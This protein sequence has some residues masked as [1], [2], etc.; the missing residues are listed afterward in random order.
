MTIIRDYPCLLH[1]GDYN[2][3]QW[4]DRPDIID[5]DF[6]L[7]DEAGCNTFS[8]AIFS[9]GQLEIGENVFD[10]G[11]LDDIFERAERGGKKLFLATPSGARPGWMGEHYPETN[12]VEANDPSQSRRPW[13]GRQTHCLSSEYFRGKVCNINRK[14]AER[15]GKHPAL[16]GWHVSNE[17]ST[18]CYCPRCLGRY[19]QFLKDR[20]HTL[21]NLNH[22]YWSSFWGHRLTSWSQ[23]DPRDNAVNIAVLD[24]RR[25]V[26]AQIVEFFEMEIAA[27]REYSDLPVTT[28]MMGLYG[29]VDYWKLAKP[30]DFI[31]DDCYPTWYPGITEEV[32]ANFAA[33]HDMHY[34]M[35]KKPFL[36]MESC[37]GIPQYKPYVRLRRPHEFQ[38]EMLLALGHGADGTMYFQWRK[39]RGNLEQHHGAVVGH[40][41]TNQ[42][43]MFK[44]VADYGAHLGRIDEIVDARRTPQ[45][46]VILD[47]ENRWALDLVSGFGGAKVLNYDNTVFQNYQALWSKNYQL[48]VLDGDQD[49]ADCNMA[50]APMLYLLK[51]G[52]AER[53]EAF[54][55]AGGTFVMTYL[56]GCVDQSNRCFLGGNPGGPLLRKVFGIWSEDIDGLTPQTHQQIRWQHTCYDVADYAEV[57]H[58]GE[59]EVLATYV[60]EFYAGTPAV[61]VNR[62]GK[63]RAIYIGARPGLDFLTAFYDSLA[64]AAGCQRL[65]PLLPEPLRVSR[66]VAGDG[67]E[68]YFILNM[69]ETEVTFSLPGPMTDLWSGAGQCRQITLPAAGS[70]VLKA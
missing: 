62:Y 46:A 13:S 6:V 54:V 58:A 8:V 1:G 37:P 36:V 5:Q 65:L 57:I 28:N 70:V 41:G 51:D 22:H 2:P 44:A 67:S 31:A 43:M 64:G 66:R 48:T 35:K 40:D 25:F 60:N 42:T 7:M 3:D 9:W 39:G 53:I 55:A 24:W 56:S 33:L 14:L 21:D 30:C 23:I 69:A 63:G 29:I 18:E 19:H 38:R 47:W 16:A 27:V 15:Y 45:I 11:W 49:F 59:A 4:L 68:Y 50:V 61:T 32:A 20:Y 26:S 10:F 12:V 52:M 34:A 17:Y